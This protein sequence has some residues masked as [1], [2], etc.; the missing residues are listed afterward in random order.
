MKREGKREK[1]VYDCVYLRD[2]F[3]MT[4]Y[5]A[6]GRKYRFARRVP[7]ELSRLSP[8]PIRHRIIRFD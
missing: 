2:F 7:S 5:Y 8:A 1:K 3:T 6:K 4:S